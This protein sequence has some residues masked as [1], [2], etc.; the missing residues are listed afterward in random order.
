MEI[1]FCRRHFVFLVCFG[2]FLVVVLN[3]LNSTM[4]LN[5][6]REPQIHRPLAD[7]GLPLRE[8]S[9]EVRGAC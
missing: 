7:S 5:W 1:S 2:D 8:E 3:D 4:A 9:G 6:A